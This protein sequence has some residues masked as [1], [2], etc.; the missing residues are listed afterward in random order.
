M[1]RTLYGCGLVAALS[2]AGVGA[3]ARGLSAETPAK[4]DAR[5]AAAA[6]QR[7]T[8]AAMA[9]VKKGVD[10]NAPQPD[11]ATALHWAAHWNDLALAKALTAAGADPNAANDYGVTP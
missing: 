8:A 3:S 10:V 9:L 4:A 7:D 11:G 6:E 5:L 1:M 2:L